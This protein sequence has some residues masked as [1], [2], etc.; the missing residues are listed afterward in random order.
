MS[1]TNQTTHYN[2]PQ[3]IGTDT[4]GWLTDVNAG[5]AA[6]DS[7]IYQRESDIATNTGNITANTAS[8]TALGTRM[9]NAESDIT[10]L[11]T[12]VD[13]DEVVI[14]GHTSAIGSLNTTVASIASAINNDV[15][16]SVTVTVPASS[17]VNDEVTLSDSKIS[18][19]KQNFLHLDPSWVSAATAAE[20]QE[21]C[22]ALILPISE[23][24]G[25][26]TIKAF[27]GAPSVA[28]DFE[29]VIADSHY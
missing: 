29:I 21:V 22:G 19:D 25:S 17:W 24:N 9:T 26:I 16:D 7:A 15:W 23:M 27:N 6:I 18:I 11:Q 8:I 12:D 28:V 20:V 1:H 10:S 14:A 13:A 2:L 3:F 5:Y 4:P